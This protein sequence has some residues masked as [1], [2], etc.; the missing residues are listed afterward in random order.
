MLLCFCCSLRLLVQLW[1]FRFHVLH[2]RASVLTCFFAI[3]ILWSLLL[4]A[5]SRSR[6]PSAV[7]FASACWCSL[8]SD[9]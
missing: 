7:H 1:F 8:E 6:A 5:V 3:E 4:V 2:R 9:G